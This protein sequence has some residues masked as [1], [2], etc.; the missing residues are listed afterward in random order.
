ML[1]IIIP[2]YNEEENIKPIYNQLK[3]VLKNLRKKYEIIFIDDGSNDKT[4]ENLKNLALRNKTIKIIRFKRNFGQSAALAAGFNYAKGEII[5]TMDADLQ[6]HPSDIP[7]LIKKLNN[8][9]IVCGWRKNRKDPFISKRLPSF[10]SNW[11][12]RKFTKVEIHDFGCT[13]RVYKRD[14]IKDL[15]IYGELHRYIPALAKAAGYSVT[16]VQV[17]HSARKHGKT[18]YKFNRFFKGMSDLLTLAFLERFGTRPAH[19]FNSIGLFS[20]GIG[21]LILLFLVIN[22][23]IYWGTSIVRPSLYLSVI[24]IL[25]GIQFITLGLM[26]EMIT[27]LHYELEDKKFYKIKEIIN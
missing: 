22:T 15:D 6:N 14:V 25:G 17:E 18:K 16:E 1:S 20:F 21:S 19:L 11:L 10:I 5:I 13:L 7:R 9:D 24:L 27:R 2:A 26:S 3:I 23:L 12:A 8:A 4:F